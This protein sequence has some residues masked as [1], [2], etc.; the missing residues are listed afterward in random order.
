MDAYYEKNIKIWDVA[1]GLAL[2]K[3][4][5]GKIIC[6]GFPESYVVEAYGGTSLSLFADISPPCMSKKDEQL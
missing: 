4:A 6:K 3:A 5:G 1:A 2:V